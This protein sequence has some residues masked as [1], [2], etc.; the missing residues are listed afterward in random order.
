MDKQQIL[1]AYKGYWQQIEKIYQGM[2]KRARGN[3]EALK[4]ARAWRLEKLRAVCQKTRERL[5]K[6][7]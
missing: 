3:P 7:Q 4:W 5:E 6:C 1:A 2:V